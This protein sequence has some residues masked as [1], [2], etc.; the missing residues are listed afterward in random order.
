[1]RNFRHIIVIP[2]LSIVVALL[3]LTTRVNA[4]DGCARCGCLDC[5]KVCRLV[6]ET[7][8]VPV[9]CWGMKCEDFC[10]GGPSCRGCKN[11]EEVCQSTEKDASGPCVAPKDFVWYDWFPGCPKGVYTKKKLMK[12]TLTKTIPSFK[13]VVEDLCAECEAKTQDA[14]VPPGVA[15]P[16]PPNVDAK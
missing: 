1:M 15:V 2:S 10:V 12:K 11:C 6:E 16:P 5:C 14:V 4:G 9:I 3:S 8:K 13:W 7:K